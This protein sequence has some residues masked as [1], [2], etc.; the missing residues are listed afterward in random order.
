MRGRFVTVLA[1]AALVGAGLAAPAA[2]AAGGPNLAAGKAA[3]ASGV[4]GPYPAGN[5]TDGNAGSYWE[6]PNALPQW[7]QVDLG[8]SS[9]IDQVRLKLPPA[10]AWAA[11]TQTLSVQGSTNAT[12][13]S[14]LAGAREHRFDPAT[15]NTVTVDV[16]ATSVRYV[17]VTVTAN[18]GWPAGQLSGFQVRS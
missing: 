1:T 11:R 16:T 9:A 17:R 5:V 2:L 3:T 12:S 18:T 4:N 6:S 7:V 10:A 8:G 13:W 14:T 15:G